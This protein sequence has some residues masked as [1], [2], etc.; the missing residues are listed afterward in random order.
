MATPQPE[1]VGDGAE[2]AETNAHRRAPRRMRLRDPFGEPRI[3]MARRNESRDDAQERGARR[4]EV[5]A[6]WLMSARASLRERACASTRG[7]GRS[8][9]GE[10]AGQRP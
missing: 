10:L 3:A 8:R 7:S 1:R 6:H 4:V 5:A 9:R 2:A